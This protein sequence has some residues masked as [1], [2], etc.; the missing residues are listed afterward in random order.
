VDGPAVLTCT[1]C[2]YRETF[3]TFFPT[4][5]FTMSRVQEHMVLMHMRSNGQSQA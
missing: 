1:W 2:G 3:D 5:P 4:L